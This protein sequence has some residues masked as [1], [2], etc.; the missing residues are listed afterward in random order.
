[1]TMFC[2]DEE[3]LSA[4]VDRELAPV[5]DEFIS[6]HLAAC[7]V[8]RRSVTI[9]FMV[10]RE[11]P[12]ALSEEGQH[13]VYQAVQ[14]AL[15]EP[16]H[17]VTDELLA[18]WLHDGLAPADRSKVT[19]HLAECDDC[20]RAA[21]LTR[22]SNAEPVS[23]LGPL[24]ESRALN[25][26]LRSAGRDAFFS[27]WRVAAASL[28]VAIAATYVAIQWS[29]PPQS[30]TTLASAMTGS[31]PR[32]D[33]R[34]V[35]TGGGSK[36]DPMFV[37]PSNNTPGPNKSG[38]APEKGPAESHSPARFQA[39]QIFETD[40]L[41]STAPGRL[42]YGDLLKPKGVATVNVEGRAA[43]VLDEGS[44]SRIAY[45]ADAGA[46]VVELSKG[47]VFID[48]AGAEQTWEIRR[49]DRAVTLRTFRGRASA[50]A[51]GNGLRVHVLKGAAEVGPYPVER[52]R[53]VE[54]RA[55]S[56]VMVDDRLESCASLAER[57][58]G[59][60]PRTLLVLRAAAGTSSDDGP[61]RFNSQSRKAELLE[62]ANSLIPDCA[63]PIK[64]VV[65]ALDEPL[66]YASDMV[67]RAACGGSAGA[68]ICLWVGGQG[69]WHREA[70]RQASG[71]SAEEWPLRELR[72]EMVPLLAGQEI[73]KIMIGVVQ[74]RGREH[75]LEVDGIEIRRVLD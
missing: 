12:E 60:R 44:E 47:R 17:C 64:W 16:S 72:S 24:Q 37:S 3:R 48:T 38:A 52:G 67:L 15:A 66:K 58:S 2:P 21:A 55:D 14:G 5:E 6:T 35:E 71:T 73:R 19:D 62:G 23:A 29:G 30:P 11:S 53:S 32:P 54:V 36:D 28:L 45:A 40:G 56:S 8:C 10:D 34:P 22:M 59:I 61:W 42:S 57:Y 33:P 4:W 43:I 46:Y 25:L 50:E 27:F 26:V 49:A 20:R 9:A 65:I 75:S 70:L 31:D 63:D 39:L 68:R 7:E 18:A 69:G 51:D 1:M 13:R 74:E 41:S